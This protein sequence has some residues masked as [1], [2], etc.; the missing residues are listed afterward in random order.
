MRKTQLLLF[1][2][3]DTLEIF[4]ITDDKEKHY[5][6]SLTAKTGTIVG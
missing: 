1:T 2:L 5:N 3:S 4:K 6:V